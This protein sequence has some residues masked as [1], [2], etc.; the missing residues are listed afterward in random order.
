MMEHRHLDEEV[1]S[2]ERDTWTLEAGGIATAQ[3]RANAR[4]VVQ[5]LK[6]GQCD[7]VDT[8]CLVFVRTIQDAHQVQAFFAEQLPHL[9]PECIV[10]H[11]EMEWERGQKQVLQRFRNGQT[12][13][14]VCTSV[15]E[16]GIDVCDCNIV[17]RL[18][19]QLSLRSYIQSR[20]R[21]RSKLQ[22]SE[23]ILVCSQKEKEEVQ[24][25]QAL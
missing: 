15:L 20:G 12:K 16:E 24:Q 3:N 5:H 4:L 2:N 21:A 6:K 1:K 11:S 25:K 18:D 8:R 17:V 10:G 14:L 23:Y 13:L 7:G 22:P 19:C 9:G